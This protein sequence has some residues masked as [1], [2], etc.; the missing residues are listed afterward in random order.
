MKPKLIAMNRLI[1][2]GGVLILAGACYAGGF[3]DVLKPGDAAPAWKD[4][5]GVDGKT[6]SM[7]D[8]ANKE[9][10]VVVFTCCSCPA[11]EDYEDRIA[12]FVAKHAGPSAKTALVAINV[13]ATPDD[14]MPQMKERAK[15]KGFAYPF[16]YDE[17]QKIAKLY[18][19]SYTPEFFVL[20]KERK[21]VYMGAMDDHDNAK[22]A[23][24]SYLEEAVTAALAG[25][26]PATRETLARGCRI[27]W[28]RVKK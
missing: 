4:L 8:L 20:N 6:Y 16:L 12:S 28:A 15:A 11:S 3:N 22:L 19:A 25:K 5:P 17:S 23:K 9:V 7:A 1:L 21:V 27:R 14:R 18:G 24:K 26:N 13:N 10:V 2:L